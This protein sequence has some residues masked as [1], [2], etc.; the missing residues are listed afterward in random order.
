MR[1]SLSVAAAFVVGAV[2]AAGIA[3][4]TGAT[5]HRSPQKA[6]DLTVAPS[7]LTAPMSGS[8]EVPAG[9][10]DA[11]GTAFVM[12]NATEGLVCWKI[13][14]GNVDNIVAAHIH[15][16]AAGVAGPVVIPMLATGVGT[17][18]TA[19]TNQVLTGCN[20]VDSALVADL[21]ANPAQYY[22]NVHT[23]TFPAGAARGQLTLIPPKTIRRSA[24]VA[25]S[26]QVVG[27]PVQA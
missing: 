9:D 26:R 19:G 6:A 27:T 24:G 12:T 11:N 17:K 10:T 7:S 13:V 14:V 18:T 20:S 1:R 3:T 25:P 23:A 22:V 2:L 8:V 16:G 21:D 5:T 15:K 4:A